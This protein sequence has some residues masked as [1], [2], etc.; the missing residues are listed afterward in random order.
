MQVTVSNGPV[1]IVQ[2]RLA[3]NLGVKELIR[4]FSRSAKV[5]KEVDSAPKAFKPI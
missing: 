3:G 2:N 4:L 5:A 1:P